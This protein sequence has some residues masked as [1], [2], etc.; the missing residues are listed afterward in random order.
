M[1]SSVYVLVL[2]THLVMS[3]SIAQ[4][5][6][7][8]VQRDFAKSYLI[9]TQEDFFKAI[10]GITEAQAKFKAD[11]ASWSI[12][13]CAEHIAL[14]ESGIGQIIKQQ[15]ASPPDSSRRSEIKV[16]DNEVIGR[17]TNRTFK[18]QSPEMIRPTGRF[19]NL[20]KAKQ[21]FA[22]QRRT[23]IELVSTTQDD[24]LNRY[25]KHPA[26]GT[27]DLYQSYL[28]IAAHCKRHTLQIEE[29]KA[30]KNYPKK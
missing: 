3:T 8:T 18:A 15:L 2:L 25:W 17:L 27:I 1:K 28:L 22:Q 14:S 19:S 16:S 4:S 6:L 9:Q 11:S 7:T 10:E 30:N 13:D 24:L 23:N 21:L 12:L 20:E 26:T 29:I 5:K